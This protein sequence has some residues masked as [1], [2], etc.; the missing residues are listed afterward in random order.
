MS[1]PS[2]E[3]VVPLTGEI[4]SLED[5]DQCARIFAEIKELE[6]QLRSLRGALGAVLMEESTRQGT[7]TLHFKGGITAKISAPME[8]QWDQEILLEL[9]D[10][11]LPQERFDMLVTTEISYKVDNSIVRELEGANEI[12]AEII[13]RARTRFP[14]TPSVS[15]VK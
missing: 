3:L 8:T 7:K 2:T 13:G 12:Y 15:V 1:E 6:G 4:I 11:G 5:P 14:K 10:A 9:L